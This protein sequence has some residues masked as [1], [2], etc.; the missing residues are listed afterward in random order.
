[1][2]FAT[3]FRGNTLI[4]AANRVFSPAMYRIDPE[5]HYSIAIAYV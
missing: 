3:L 4:Y 2:W 5:S 1:M